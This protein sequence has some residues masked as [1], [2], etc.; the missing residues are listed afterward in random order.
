MLSMKTFYVCI[1]SLCL[2]SACSRTKVPPASSGKTVLIIYHVKPG[3]EREFQQTLSHAWDI[4][5]QERLVL[6]Q[7][8]I[9]AREM[10]D[11]DKTRFIE[12]FTWTNGNTPNNPPDSVKKIWNQMEALCET[13]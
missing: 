8:H 4:Y 3:S 10:E 13:R 2:F 11:G 12:I 1:L 9:V 6:L 7:P 5:L